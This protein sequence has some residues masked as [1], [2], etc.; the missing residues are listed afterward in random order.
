MAQMRDIQATQTE[1]ANPVR[2]PIIGQTAEGTNISALQLGT[3]TR[4]VVL[5]G[6]L[7]AGFAPATVMLADE[8][9][10]YYATHL[11]EIPPKIKLHIISNANPDS[12]PMMGERDGR[13]NSNEV[14]LNRNWDCDWKRVAKWGSANVSGG[15]APF[16]ELETQALREYFTRTQPVAVIFWEARSAGGLAAPG[17]C[18]LQSLFSE[19]LAQ[20]YGS[21]AG[22]KIA[23][24]EAYAVNG[25]ATNWLDAQGIPAISVLLPDYN[26]PDIERNLQAV[27]ALLESYR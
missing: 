13:L 15:S 26:N 20:I 22:Y 17:G 5:V 14:D 23:Q 1:L 3:G 9:A 12:P 19:S 8:V 4:N 10:D 6:G 2:Q 18:G 11:Q 24:F 21:A 25:D 16:S 7:H 27:R